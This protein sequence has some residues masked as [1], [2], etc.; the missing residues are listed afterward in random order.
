[1]HKV[2]FQVYN[3]RLPAA[4]H[5]GLFLPLCVQK[6]EIYLVIIRSNDWHKA[7]HAFCTT[8]YKRKNHM[9]IGLDYTCLNSLRNK[10]RK[11]KTEE[12]WVA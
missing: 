3:N 5:S 12:L 6:T 10:Y 1:M 11:L 9:F 4:T 8:S 2:G 7:D